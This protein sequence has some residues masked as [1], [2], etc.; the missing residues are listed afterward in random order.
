MASRLAVAAIPA[1]VG[2]LFLTPVT[3]PAILVGDDDSP[4]VVPTVT[5]GAPGCAMYCNEPAVKCTAFCDEPEHACALFCDEPE[6]VPVCTILCG[7]PEGA[8]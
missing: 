3:V 1:A 2:L 5:A 8:N 7:K 6:G 4:A